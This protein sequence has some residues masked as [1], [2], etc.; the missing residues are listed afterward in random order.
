MQSQIAIEHTYVK[1]TKSSGFLRSCPGFCPSFRK[2]YVEWKIYFMLL[3]R[4]HS[5]L[6]EPG[7]SIAVILFTWHISA[8]IDLEARSAS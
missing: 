3:Q 7:G 6:D 2:G 1:V 8:E 4:E 5:G